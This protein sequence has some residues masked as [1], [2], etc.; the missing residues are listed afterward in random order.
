[1]FNQAIKVL[2]SS[3]LCIALSA[4]L[5]LGSLSHK[6]VRILKKE[7]FVLTEEG[8]SLGLPERLLF[9]FNEANIAPGQEDKITRLATQ[10]HGYNLNRVKIV[11]HT[12]NI[13]SADYNLKLSRQRAQSVAN[14]FL[15]NGFSSQNVYVIGKGAEQPILEND[16][17]EHRAAN[18]RV[19][20]VIIP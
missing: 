10:L 3:A 7:G 12:D 11:G 14:L 19:S 2:L 13:G 1:M 16:T 17:K 4:C 5:S 15:A 6:Q 20:I 18:R 9:G 8:W